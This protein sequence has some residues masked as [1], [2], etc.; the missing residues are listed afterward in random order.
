MPS[1]STGPGAFGAS[2]ARHSHPPTARGTGPLLP[3]NE[4]PIDAACSKSMLSATPVI[5]GLA[6]GPAGLSPPAA[7]RPRSSADRSAGPDVIA[8]SLRA[9][10]AVAV[11]AKSGQSSAVRG[12]SGSSEHSGTAL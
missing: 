7:R 11:R 6:P 5:V 12:G 2:G 8:L 9:V 4:I 10:I 1:H 3:V